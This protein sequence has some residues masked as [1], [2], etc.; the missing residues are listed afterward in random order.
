MDISDALLTLYL[1]LNNIA[2]MAL[3]NGSVNEWHGI[4]TKE[5]PSIHLI[6]ASKHLTH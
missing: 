1:H 6:M 5:N 4:K 3:M 2:P